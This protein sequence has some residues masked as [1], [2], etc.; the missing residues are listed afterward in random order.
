MKWWLR[1]QWLRIKVYASENY[2]NE[3]ESLIIWYAVSFAL[4]AAFYFAFPWELPVWLVITYL[5]GVLLLLY[6]LNNILA[7]AAANGHKTLQF[8]QTLL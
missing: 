2:Y 4:G 7:R 8:R 1:K 6:L 5:E 3:A